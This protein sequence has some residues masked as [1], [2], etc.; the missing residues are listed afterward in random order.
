MEIF[1]RYKKKVA[2][3]IIGVGLYTVSHWLINFCR[4]YEPER[5]DNKNKCFNVTSNKVM[6][7]VSFDPIS[8]PRNEMQTQPGFLMA[9]H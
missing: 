5:E 4:T 8:Y 1:K 6:Q 9:F 2:W 7:V 3:N